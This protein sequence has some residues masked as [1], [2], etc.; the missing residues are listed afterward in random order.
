MHRL[1]RFD[2]E[3]AAGGGEVDRLA[4]GHAARRP[5]RSASIAHARAA[6][7]CAYRASTAN[8]SACSASPA[9]SAVASPNATWHVGLPAA[10]RV[11][12]HARQV[13]VHQRIRVDQLDRR[14]GGVDVVDRRT[15]QLARR[16][17]EQRAHALAALSVA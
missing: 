6:V 9:S 8:A 13:V 1:E 4:A 2:G 10:H 12:V 17:R 7:R 5:T 3:R 15:G 16:I 11:V 14:G